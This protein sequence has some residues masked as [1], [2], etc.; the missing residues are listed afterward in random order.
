MGEKDTVEKTLEAYN[1]VFVDIVNGFLFQGESVLKENSLSDAQPFSMYK[2]D[3]K[4]YQV[5]MIVLQKMWNGKE[6]NQRQ[7]ISS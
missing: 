3:G 2:A 6:V 4:L 1:D 5:E 7:W